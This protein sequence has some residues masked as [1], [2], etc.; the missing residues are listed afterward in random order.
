MPLQRDWH[1]EASRKC[2]VG[3]GHRKTDT[4]FSSR[5]LEVL[6]MC[7]VRQDTKSCK[8]FLLVLGSLF[9]ERKRFLE[10]GLRPTTNDSLKSFG[11]T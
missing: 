9:E 6:E 4:L 7:W 3:T 11:P 10:M 5:S 2:A 8:D 1:H